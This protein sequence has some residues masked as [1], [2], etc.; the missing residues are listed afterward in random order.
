ATDVSPTEVT[1]TVF[2][3]TIYDSPWTPQKAANKVLNNGSRWKINGSVSDGAGGKSYYRVA[4]NQWVDQSDFDFSG[5]YDVEPS[6]TQG[7]EDGTS[8]DDDNY[9][10]KPFFYYNA[11]SRSEYGL[12]IGDD[13]TNDQIKTPEQMKQYADSVLQTDPVVELTVNLSYQDTSMQLGDTLYLNADPLGLE[14]M[15]T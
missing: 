8:S 14:T 12:K 10:F 1:N 11:A 4:T 5:Q 3:A 15:I 2:G 7:Q 9:V 13:I 6:D